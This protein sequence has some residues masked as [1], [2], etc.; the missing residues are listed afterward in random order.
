M[1]S[2]ATR[3]N[4]S[5]S[6]GFRAPNV[7]DA[8]RIF[9]SNTASKQLIVPNPNINPE[10]TYNVDL[11]ISQHLF[12]KVRMEITGFYT[13]F[14][15][16][17]ALA[18]FQFNGKDSIDYNG[19]TVKV[20]ANQNVNKAFLYGFNASLSAGILNNFNFSSTINYTYG[21]LKPFGN[22]RIP[23]DHIPP[24]YG[25]TSLSYI[26]EKLNFDLYALYNGWKKIEEYNPSGEDN[27][28]YATKD[29]TP[30]WLTLNFK[31]S[32]VINKNISV[33]AGVENILDR[34][35]RNFASGF[36]APGRNFIFALRSN[37]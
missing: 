8:S 28:Q 13:W 33:Q 30:S 24:L 34:N 31:S 7:D 10:Y 26:D 3:I 27:A 14:K 5:F 19:S 22:Q 2:D 16:A 18:P 32:V 4:S 35:Y 15:N 23:L 9:E 25:K 17:I 1:P 20:F 29:G 6:T 36:S 12:S 37:F 11:G 21:R